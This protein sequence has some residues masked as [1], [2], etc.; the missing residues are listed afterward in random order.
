M[1]LPHRELATAVGELARIL[2]PDGRVIISYLAIPTTMRRVDGR[3]Y[4]ALSVDA[5]HTLL[6]QAGMRLL[7]TEEQ[8]DAAREGMVWYTWAGACE[9]GIT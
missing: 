5:L 6:V 1:H 9:E 2:C 8:A 4:T 7:A 3:L